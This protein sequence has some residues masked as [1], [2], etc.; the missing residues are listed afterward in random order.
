V[1][2]LSLTPGA[3]EADHP[4]A[5]GFFDGI[6]TGPTGATWLGR[7]AGAGG[8]VVRIDIGWDAP[9]T[10]T[11]PA[12]FNARNPADPMYN[13]TAADAAIRAARADGL[14][15]IASFTGAPQW[16]EG[17]GR[18]ADADPGTW[19]PQPQALADYGV[20]L[21][22][23]YS[24][25]YPD[26]LRPG[27][28][29]PRVEAFQ[30][31]N[32]PNLNKY[33]TPQWVG[34]RT[35]SPEW[36][37]RMLNAFYRAI[38]SVDPGALVVTGGTGPFGD[39]EP[40]GMRIM[41]ARFVRD[42]LCLR[43]T[44][45]A[46]ISTGCKDPAHFDVLAHHPYSVGQ[47]DT[48][49]LNADDVSIPDLGKLT[50]LLR[51]AELAGD[52]LP[53]TYHR[54]WVTEVGYNTSPPN[55]GGVPVVEDARWVEQTLQLLWS[56]GVDVITW[57]T[58]VDQPPIPSY[59]DTSQSGVFFLNGRPKPAWLAFHF[60]LVAWRQ[61]G[62]AVEVWG[63]APIGGRLQIEQ[64]SRGNWKTVRALNVARHSTF[65]TTISASGTVTLRAQIGVATSLS[66]HQG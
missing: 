48:A 14:R 33:L 28:T 35:A 20:A 64:L 62:S 13:F 21:G 34:G 36:Y 41:P 60:P 4:F 18:P 63:R 54:L 32:E 25:H 43:D 53:H 9:N 15:V 55:P 56:Q 44:G 31:W 38:K 46:L 1:A 40:G 6:F 3:A 26:P 61:H 7:A 11:R 42:L 52:A 58:I 22:L 45:S 2:L 30:L 51:A 66:W 57:N 23:R 12:H 65:L 37:R 59:A 8:D 49:A 24:G 39:P 50:R 16:A 19:R 47:P 17:P 29:L 27:H 10:P 5:L